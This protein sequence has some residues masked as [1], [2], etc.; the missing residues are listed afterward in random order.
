M[1]RLG[2][3]TNS[4]PTHNS[5]RNVKVD[6]IFGALPYSSYVSGNGIGFFAAAGNQ[7]IMHCSFVNLFYF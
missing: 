1:D 2:K 7:Q 3:V 4:F 5:Y 6:K